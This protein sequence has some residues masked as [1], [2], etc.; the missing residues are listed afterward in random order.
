MNVCCHFMEEGVHNVNFFQYICNYV[1]RRTWFRSN[2][3]FL[4]YNSAP[5]PTKISSLNEIN[6]MDGS[7]QEKNPET[8]GVQSI[9]FF[10]IKLECVTEGIKGIGKLHCLKKA[11]HQRREWE[12]F[13]WDCLIGL[14]VE[15]EDNVCFQCHHLSGG[16]ICGWGHRGNWF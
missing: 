13:Y 10:K 8:E 12:T 6:K 7:R 4:N 16:A 5:P 1:W 15:E 11:K 2:K 14:E 3:S 9:L